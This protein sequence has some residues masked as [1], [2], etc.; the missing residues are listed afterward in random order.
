MPLVGPARWH[1][2]H[3]REKTTLGMARAANGSASIRTDLCLV[4]P[5]SKN[6]SR[7]R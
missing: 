3:E 6:S 1:E 2:T 7:Q 5:T 4:I